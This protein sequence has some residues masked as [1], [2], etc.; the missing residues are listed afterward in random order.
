MTK[1]KPNSI[2]V[3]L[4]V[5]VVILS[6]FFAWKAYEANTAK[7]VATGASQVAPTNGGKTTIEIVQPETS[8]VGINI[9][10]QTKGGA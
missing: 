2:M 4:I 7:P 5:L 8:N 1:Q 9:V 10:N 6:A 3:W